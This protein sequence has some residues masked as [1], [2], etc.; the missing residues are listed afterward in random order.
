MIYFNIFTNIL[1]VLFLGYYLIT[2]L[3]WYNYKLKRV[4][5]NF[6]KK[7]WHTLY[8]IS[9]IILYL[10]LDILYF[11]IYF[12]SFY[13][14]S[15]IL[16]KNSLDRVL[17]FTNRAKRFFIILFSISLFINILYFYNSLDYNYRLGILSLILAYI[18]SNIL[19]K[20]W[21]NILKNRAKNKISNL[22]NISN[23][24]IIAITASYGKTSIKNYLYQILKYK[25][26]VY[27]T[28]RSVNT[29]A[30]IVLDINQNLPNDTQIY[31][32][33][34][35]ARQKG[36][37][38]DIVDLINPQYAILGSVGEQHIEYF[39]T[40]DN[41]INTKKEILSSKKL[42][43]ALVH[44]SVDIKSN[45]IMQ[46]FPS[47]LKIKSSTLNGITFDIDINSVRHRFKSSV[48]GGFNAI[49]LTSVIFMCLELDFRIDEVKDYIK[50]IQNINHRLQLVKSNGKLILDDSFNGNLNGMI[51]AINI[52]SSYTK[53]KVI[54]TPGLIESTSEANKQLAF[55][56]DKVFDIVI[57]TGELNQNILKSNINTAKVI[58]LK[59]K[60]KM[61]DYIKKYTQ[62]D[63][64]ILFAND[65]PS[66][67]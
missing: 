35:G 15:L 1:L 23:L 16:W 20:I 34:A 60:S 22:Q 58:L 59:D 41:I 45:E 53:R 42:I 25:Y 4:I 2:V 12:Y 21:F 17:V 43:Y 30:G 51:E 56:I 9:P 8:F 63:D 55:H 14:I 37:I 5:F 26:R 39:K 18:L 54:I 19:E 6:Y 10:L 24:K 49:N 33:E 50:D 40:L 47:N 36:D 52:S 65:A 57:L 64:L 61:K 38:K 44:D 3:Q 27:K 48:L 32:C 66:F 11:S 7:N 46:Q 29:L 62:K 28:P 13:I 31:I 67:I